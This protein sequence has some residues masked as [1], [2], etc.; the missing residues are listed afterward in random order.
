MNIP[1]MT[2]SHQIIRKECRDNHGIETAFHLAVLKLRDKY[3][4]LAKMG[5]ADDTEIH[6]ALIVQHERHRVPGPPS[7]PRPEK[8]NEVA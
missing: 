5:I 1:G 6:L 4:E 7:P 3:Y 8:W 2:A